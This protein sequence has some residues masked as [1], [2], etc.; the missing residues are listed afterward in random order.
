MRCNIIRRLYVKDL[1]KEVCAKRIW[2]VASAFKFPS[3]P[4]EIVL[5]RRA[6]SSH[7][8]RVCFGIDMAH[9]PTATDEAIA[10]TLR[11]HCYLAERVVGCSFTGSLARLLVFAIA[12][13]GNI[14]LLSE[15]TLR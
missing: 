4:A 10:L 13:T 8:F 12:V 3:G 14:L 7:S 1:R 5:L 15:D 9:L 2:L 11:G 6:I